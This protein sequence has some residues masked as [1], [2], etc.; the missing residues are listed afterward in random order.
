M[1]TKIHYA[2]TKIRKE[3]PLGEGGM[4]GGGGEETYQS[5]NCHT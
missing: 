2:L 5:S 3:E 1:L 4:G